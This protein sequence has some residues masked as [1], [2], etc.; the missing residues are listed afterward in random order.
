MMDITT[1]GKV[2]ALKKPIE[3][4]QVATTPYARSDEYVEPAY[5]NKPGAIREQEMWPWNIHGAFH[6][7]EQKPN[8]SGNS[9]VTRL[10]DVPE[11]HLWV[12]SG[13]SSERIQKVL[14]GE[15]PAKVVVHTEFDSYA[16]HLTRPDNKRGK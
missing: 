15:Q 16:A 1:R 12:G 9:T 8:A 5:G 6:Y 14:N 3:I 11:L 2:K 10:L 4:L 7:T 13:S